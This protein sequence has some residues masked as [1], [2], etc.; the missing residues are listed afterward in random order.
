MRH[1]HSRAN[2]QCPPSGNRLSV[3]AALTTAATDYNGYHEG[4]TDRYNISFSNWTRSNTV[5]RID[6]GYCSA[7]V[8]LRAIIAM[9]LA[10]TSVELFSSDRPRLCWPYGIKFLAAHHATKVHSAQLIN[11]YYT[12]LIDARSRMLLIASVA[13][14]VHISRPPNYGHLRMFHTEGVVGQVRM[15]ITRGVQ[16]GDLLRQTKLTKTT[17]MSLVSISSRSLA[18]LTYSQLLLPLK[19]DRLLPDFDIDLDPAVAWV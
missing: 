13:V 3:S 19:W 7:A 5:F 10:D 1:C 9:L 14:R 11:R 17:S 8:R 4:T 16:P 2:A 18:K 15:V 6:C 12:T